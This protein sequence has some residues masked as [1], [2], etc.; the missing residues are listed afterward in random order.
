[1]NNT[2]NTSTK[3]RPLDHEAG[4]KLCSLCGLCMASA[5]PAEESIAGCVFTTGWLGKQEA[6]LFGQERSRNDYDEMLFGISRE[7]FVSRITTP[8]PNVQFSGIITSIAKKAFEAGL[9]DAV[10]TAHR[11]TEDYMLPGPVL[12][13]STETILAGAGS[14]P[15]LA[16][17]LISLDKAYTEGIKRLLVI[18]TSCQVQNLREFKRRFS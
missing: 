8:L 12:A 7:R 5:W 13:R 14:K 11:S 17:S 6:N 1:M 10:I 2:V 4:K 9:V 18:G 3:N 16:P 15:V